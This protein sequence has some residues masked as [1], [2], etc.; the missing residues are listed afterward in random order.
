M[1]HYF[2][3]IHFEAL[4]F[5]TENSEA[6]PIS[7]YLSTFRSTA[8][9]RPELTGLIHDV[10]DRVDEFGRWLPFGKNNAHSLLEPD[11]GYF[12]CFLSQNLIRQGQRAGSAARRRARGLQVR[13]SRRVRRKSLGQPPAVC[14]NPGRVCRRVN[15]RLLH[16]ALWLGVLRFHLL[17]FLRS[18]ALR[19]FDG[20]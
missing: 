2:A 4:E 6:L 14:L 18:L 16:T 17:L 1:R 19:R 11:P 8:K 7:T 9:G 20:D 12:P 3:V 10:S 15:T 13:P 5:S